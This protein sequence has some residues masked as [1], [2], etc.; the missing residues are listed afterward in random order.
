[1]RYV[2]VSALLLIVSCKQ[3][4]PPTQTSPKFAA[5]TNYPSGQV[6]VETSA[7]RVP[8]MDPA[9]P[10]ELTGVWRWMAPHRTSAVLVWSVCKGAGDTRSCVVFAGDEAAKIDI[11]LEC[12]AGWSPPSIESAADPEELVIAG[13]DGR[14][15]WTR[16]IS[17]RDGR[18][19]CGEQK[20]PEGS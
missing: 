18:W 20:R 7:P 6:L 13:E 16:A 19:A 1:M 2:F 12:P 4:A 5:V 17:Q 15:A 10:A 11:A 3:G 9:A 8:A 14:S